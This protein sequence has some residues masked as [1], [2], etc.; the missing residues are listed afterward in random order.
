MFT[1]NTRNIFPI[2]T[3]IATSFSHGFRNESKPK[4]SKKLSCFVTKG[5]W[6]TV[7]QFL[8]SNGDSMKSN[9]ML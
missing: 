1:L 9:N 7:G 8:L 5:I 3:V 2:E 4:F 6:K